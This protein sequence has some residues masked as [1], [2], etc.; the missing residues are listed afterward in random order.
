M[1]QECIDV[2]YQQ[3]SF[4]DNGLF[5]LVQ[6]AEV[7]NGRIAMVAFALL[8]AVETWKAGPGLDALNYLMQDETKKRT[9]GYRNSLR[10]CMS[11]ET[12][13]FQI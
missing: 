3:G 2:A 8:I 10:I 9:C 7:V 13:W 1:F 11:D 6:K 4:T 12:C 5:V